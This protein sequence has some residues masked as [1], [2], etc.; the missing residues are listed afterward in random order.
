MAQ[1]NASTVPFF[2]EGYTFA[3]RERELLLMENLLHTQLNSVR[4]ELA[5]VRRSIMSQ[6]YLN[7]PGAPVQGNAEQKQE[8]HVG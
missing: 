1:A 2:D 6:E 3:D 8:P 4:L 5:I 7:T